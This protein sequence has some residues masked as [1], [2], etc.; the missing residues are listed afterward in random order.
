M[1]RFGPAY[2]I[3]DKPNSSPTGSAGTK[4]LISEAGG[5]LNAALVVIIEV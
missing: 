1:V 2:K 4:E 3:V 5:V